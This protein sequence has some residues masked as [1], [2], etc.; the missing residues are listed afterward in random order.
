[1]NS[2]LIKRIDDILPSVML[3]SRI[4]VG[5]CQLLKDLDYPM[6]SNFRANDVREFLKNKREEL[7]GRD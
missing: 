6:D 5:T 2:D 7:N 3:G 4:K 1:M